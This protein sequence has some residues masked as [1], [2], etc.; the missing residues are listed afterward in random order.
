M[1]DLQSK[2]HPGSGRRK[3]LESTRVAKVTTS[4]LMI[5]KTSYL[6]IILDK[7]ICLLKAF[8]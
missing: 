1:K 4:Q 5:L 7:E 3:A 2:I 8:T 6:T